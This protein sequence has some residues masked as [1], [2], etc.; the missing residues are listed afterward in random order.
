MP[1]GH[2]RGACLDK[3]DHLVVANSGSLSN[4]LAWSKESVDSVELRIRVLR[5]LAALSSGWYAAGHRVPV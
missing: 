5:V 4:A 3:V 2:S 1:L